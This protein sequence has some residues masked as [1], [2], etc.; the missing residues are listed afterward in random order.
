[1]ASLAAT[2]LDGVDGGH[3]GGLSAVLSGFSPAHRPGMSLP[4]FP[5][6]GRKTRLPESQFGKL[7]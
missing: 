6:I 1:M 3:F 4:E 7:V 5:S 2:V